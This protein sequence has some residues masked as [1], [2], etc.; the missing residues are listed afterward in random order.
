MNETDL[1]SES[2]GFL[3]HRVTVYEDPRKKGVLYLKW[4][5]TRDDG[6]RDWERHSLGMTLR[7]ERGREIRG[8]KQ[9]ARREAE[10]Q[11]DRLSGR[12]TEAPV[13]ASDF[14]VPAAGS[15]HAGA[16]GVEGDVGL[17][18]AATWVVISDPKT[19]KYPV[20]TKNAKEIRAM[21][22][23]AVRIWCGDAGTDVAWNDVGSAQ[24]RALG[25]TRVNELRANGHVGLHDAEK[26]VRRIIT[27]ANW[28][29][30]EGK[31]L[32]TACVAPRSWKRE[33]RK[34]WGEV[35]K[36]PVPRP[37][38]PKHTLDEMRRLVVVAQEVDPRF[39]LLMAFGA[40]QRLG[41]VATCW[42]SNLDTEH[43][44]LDVPDAGT[45]GGGKILL[46][47]GQW[48]AWLRAI[49]PGG[50][51]ERCERELSDYRLFMSGKLVGRTPYGRRG[52]KIA[53]PERQ[54]SLTHVGPTAIRK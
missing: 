22:E 6:T 23:I 41:Q 37:A 1:W 2:F 44:A 18:V 7:D 52:A 36:A 31:I 46:T 9:R 28:L 25:R 43:R 49:G 19:G 40:E 54:A 45:K 17:T 26:L 33:L 5:V 16:A 8:I 53:L 30:D 29:R 39:D 14:P 51:L 38:K 10:A 24:I 4:R 13:P 50:Y 15:S 48:A 21:L 27:V 3:P 20:L 35:A 12:V 47:P 34:Y 32:L 42:R 11:Y